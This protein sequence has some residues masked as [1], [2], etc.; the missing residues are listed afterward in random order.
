[1]KW[2]GIEWNF[3][4]RTERNGKGGEHCLHKDVLLYLGN[5]FLRNVFL[6]FYG[7]TLLDWTHLVKDKFFG[8]EILTWKSFRHGIFGKVYFR[9]DI[10]FRLAIWGS[11]FLDRTLFG[12]II[13]GQGKFEHSISGQDIIG[14]GILGH[15]IQHSG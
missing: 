3:S 12:H 9:L 15:L 11:S 5:D 13:F 1:M 2:K 6:S 10:F 14:K 7:R 4:E 8:Q